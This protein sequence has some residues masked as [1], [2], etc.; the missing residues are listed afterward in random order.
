MIHKKISLFIVV[1]LLQQAAICQ[2]P[3][4]DALPKIVD[5]T[6]VLQQETIPVN[7]GKG[8]IF[9][10]PVSQKWFYVFCIL[11]LLLGL[12]RTFYA[13]YF[14]T[15]FKVFFNSS[16]RQSQLTDQL[17]LARQPSL[18]L[19]IFF[20]LSA[21]TFIYL[22]SSEHHSGLAKK[23]PLFLILSALLVGIIYIIKAAVLQLTA[24]FTG[25]KEQVNTYIF[26]IF[27]INKVTGIL[28]LP[29][30]VLYIFGPP[31]LR[32]AIFWAAIFI[33]GV[34]FLL[35]YYRSF[36]LLQNKLRVSRFQ[37]FLF[38]AGVEILPLMIIYKAGIIFLEKNL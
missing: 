28:L 38:I 32:S 37:F 14:S 23:F 33:L 26:I 7:T 27:L 9:K 2:V 5:T 19:N 30:S 18:L 31:H 15:L 1:L 17:Q 10:P 22:V 16:L 36:G 24:Y 13:R 8:N 3:V 6:Q 29:V 20:A 4:T 12:F 21:G 25:L 11:A 35:R 34:L